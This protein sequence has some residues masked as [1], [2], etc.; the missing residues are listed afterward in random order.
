MLLPTTRRL[1]CGC[2]ARAHRIR[3]FL[4]WLGQINATVSRTSVE[5]DGQDP[6]L[7]LEDD[8]PDHCVVG[9]GELGEP[10]GQLP[11]KNL[12]LGLRREKRFVVLLSNQMGEPEA[13]EALC[14]EEAHALAG[15]FT[16]D[17]LINALDT[18]PVEFEQACHDEAWGCAY[19]RV[20]RAYLD[21][22][23]EAA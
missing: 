16:V 2:L 19:S 23:R 21:A 22:I 14:H 6:F 8:F 13:V 12:R 4:G 3:N 17:R 7:V 11:L 9:L 20:W 1:L 18:D 15:N 10:I 5:I